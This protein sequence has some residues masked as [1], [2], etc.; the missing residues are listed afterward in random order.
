MNRPASS[1]TRTWVG[2]I[3][4]T[5]VSAVIAATAHHG[6]VVVIAI[7]T[8]AAIKADL[9]LVDFM[10]AGH[11]EPQWL[12]LYRLWIGIVTIVLIAGNLV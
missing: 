11:A 4:L 1:L 2:L 3:G 5:I 6:A 9:V 7:F 10:E 12:W 8:I